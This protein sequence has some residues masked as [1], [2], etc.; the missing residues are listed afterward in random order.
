MG[1][2]KREKDLSAEAFIKEVRAER[3]AREEK[4]RKNNPSSS[5]T[6]ES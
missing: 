5:I 4:A 6:L 1:L 3:E 2:F